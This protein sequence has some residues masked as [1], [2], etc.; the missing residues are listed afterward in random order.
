[1]DA[2][3]ALTGLVSR[4]MAL[5]AMPRRRALPPRWKGRQYWPMRIAALALAGVLG[6][7]VPAARANAQPP[8]KPTLVVLV[9]IDQFRADYLDRFGP[10]MTGGI[11]RMMRDGAR[12]T[13][14]HQDHAITE[15]A[16]GHAT[17]LSGRFPRSTG[18]M[19]NSIGVADDSKPLLGGSYGVGASPRRFKGTTLADW[20]HTADPR[21][22]ALSV[23][24]KD[25][26]AILPIGTSKSEVYWYSPDGMFSTSSYYRD[27]LPAWVGAFNERHLPQ[28][29]AG[30]HWTLLLADSAYHEADSVPAE[31]N[32]AG[33]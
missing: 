3:L 1:M 14:A 6:L 16:P 4:S 30:K 25:R 21:S 27:S 22:R 2:P 11:A 10:Q 8:R 19:M 24:M 17:L 15:T 26:A 18:I 13:D 33:Y 12:F 20:L 32:G 29:Y 5:G 28:S 7:V 9:T 23:S 31:S